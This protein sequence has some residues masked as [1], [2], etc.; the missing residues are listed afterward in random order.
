MLNAGWNT[1]HAISS[2]SIFKGVKNKQKKTSFKRAEFFLARMYAQW[3]ENGGRVLLGDDA[4]GGVIMLRPIRFHC[5]AV[6]I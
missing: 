3:D 5:V 6:W 4:C 1:V 2:H